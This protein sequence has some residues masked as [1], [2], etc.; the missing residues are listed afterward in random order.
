MP[1]SGSEA[2]TIRTPG[3]R[4]RSGVGSLP[5]RRGSKA[6]ELIG[7]IVCISPTTWLRMFNSVDL[8]F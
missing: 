6:N 7:I 8:P 1:I 5:R 2:V 4:A 3:K